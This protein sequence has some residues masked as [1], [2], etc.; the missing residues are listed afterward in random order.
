MRSRS[1]KANWPNGKATKAAIFH[2]RTIVARIAPPTIDDP[3]SALLVTLAECGRVEL[4]FLQKLLR[5]PEPE[6]IAQLAG[7]IYL[8]PQSQS[9]ETDDDYLSGNV[10]EK[11]LFA[12][13]AVFTDARYLANV[14]ALRQVQPADLTP[15]EIDA[16]LG[17][18]W[19]PCAEVQAFVEE[20]LGERGVEVTHADVIGTWS[21]KGSFNVRL[22]VAN[23]TEWGTDRTSALDL[24]EDA[25]NLRTPTVY[26]PVP[27][28]DKLV[29][30]G[31]A[32]E[33]ARDKQ[34]KLKEPTG[35]T[36]SASAPSMA[37][38]CNCPA[39]ATPSRCVFTRRP[40]CGA[41][42]RPTTRCWPTPWARARPTPW[43]PP[44]SN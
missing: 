27:K 11:L 10:R 41:S 2:E 9:W 7:L 34:Q 42:C 19:L 23:T 1:T 44:P 35:S 20:L 5:L 28:S 40:P 24:L 12:E 36:A 38:I 25:L 29:V 43:S 33:A 31:P 15:S 8:N 32:T 39:R 30:N 4:K 18:S 14:E 26:D 37:T 16:R 17:S 3:R 22:A 6:V 13:A 21:V